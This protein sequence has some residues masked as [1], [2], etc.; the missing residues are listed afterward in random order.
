MALLCASFV[1]AQPASADEAEAHYRLAITLRG[2][3][4]Y[5]EALRDSEAAIATFE[6]YIAAVEKSDPAAAERAKRAV[7]NLEKK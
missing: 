3:G 6:R 5:Q 1:F 7:T 2:Q 4:K